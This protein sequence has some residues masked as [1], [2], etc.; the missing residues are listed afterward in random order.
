MWW[1]W[2][3]RALGFALNTSVET[4]CHFSPVEPDSQRL[5]EQVHVF[6]VPLVVHS[7]RD[8][9]SCG[10][11][12]ADARAN[13]RGTP[14]TSL[15]PATA[16]TG[17]ASTAASV[18]RRA[19]VALTSL[20]DRYG[21]LALI[22]SPVRRTALGVVA[23]QTVAAGQRRSRIRRCSHSAQHQRA[24]QLAGAAGGVTVGLARNRLAA[25][26]G[27]RS[28]SSI[29]TLEPS[30]SPTTCDA[31]RARSAIRSATRSAASAIDA[32]ARRCSRRIPAGR[33]S[34]C[35]SRRTRAPVA[36]HPSGDIAAVQEDD[37]ARR[38]LDLEV[39]HGRSPL[40]LVSLRRWR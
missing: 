33:E 12:R 21:G 14:L 35:G 10:T 1:W 34:G 16:S 17:T 15:P 5:V 22:P 20:E 38:R 3:C 32:Q 19:P 7:G 8:R 25:A 40:L 9:L 2:D 39:S 36:P 24:E 4:R 26:S 31:A 28:A 18:A 11:L 30:D 13:S 23:G 29:A 37:R 6:D 27:C